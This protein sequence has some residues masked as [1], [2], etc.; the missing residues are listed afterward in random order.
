MTL[1]F[2]VPTYASVSRLART[3]RR[4]I[5]RP[6]A[7]PSMVF[8]VA[9]LLPA[10]LL[11]T[12]VWLNGWQLQVVRS[13]SMAPTYRTGTLLIT[14]PSV[15]SDVRPGDALL[16]TAPWLNRKLVTHRVR[17]VVEDPD[18]TRRFITRGDANDA[19]DPSPVPAREVRGIVQ[20]GVPKLGTL[21]WALRGSRGLLSLV[22]APAALLAMS[23]ARELRR[24]RQ[25]RCLTCGATGRPRHV[26]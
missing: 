14:E 18:G 11:L 2:P 23:E 20:W 5:L 8:A 10:A 1:S 15:S 22:V 12:T 24:R 3:G 16:F 9:V 7:I 6:M 25:A 4:T 26:G 13:D 21:L 17:V 19:D